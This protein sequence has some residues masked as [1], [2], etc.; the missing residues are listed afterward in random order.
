MS[1]ETDEHAIA[2]DGEGA[3]NHVSRK[4]L[5]RRERVARAEALAEAKERKVNSNPDIKKKTKGGNGKRR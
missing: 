2:H 4:E 5:A 3:A 1:K